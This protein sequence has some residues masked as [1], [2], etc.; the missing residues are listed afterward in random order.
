MTPVPFPPPAHV[1]ELS[2]SC[3]GRFLMPQICR[4]LGPGFGLRLHLRGSPQATE[5]EF[6][7][8]LWTLPPRYCGKCC[9]LS[10]DYW[11]LPPAISN[12]FRSGGG[13]KSGIS[14]Y[15]THILTV[16]ISGPIEPGH[17]PYCGE[18][19]E[20]GKHITESLTSNPRVREQTQP[21][22]DI[23]APEQSHVSRNK[24]QSNRWEPQIV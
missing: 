4:R 6:S 12:S 11:S 20:P 1:Y 23:Q 19:S 16:T 15:F 5:K 13:N 3:F 8:D 7:P 24:T 14:A 22:G 2:L 10:G 17:S 18:K 9:S 21:G